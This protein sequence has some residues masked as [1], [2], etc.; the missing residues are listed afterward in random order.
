[1]AEE[2]FFQKMFYVKHGKSKVN[3]RA[4]RV[5]KLRVNTICRNGLSRLTL[6]RPVEKTGANKVKALQ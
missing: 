1:M 5:K 2:R 4:Q 6:N 3:T